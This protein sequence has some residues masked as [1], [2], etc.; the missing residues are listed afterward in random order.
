MSASR[1]AAILASVYVLVAGLYIVLSGRV[2][3]S[4]ARDVQELQVLETYKG[5]GFVLVTALMLFGLAWALGR[6]LIALTER[7]E[8]HQSA[9]LAA[10][11]SASAGLFAASV[12]HDLNNLLMVID[13]CAKEVRLL[14]PDTHELVE[15]IELATARGAQLSKRLMGAASLAQHQ[16][17]E[18]VELGALAAESLELL[19][20]HRLARERELLLDAP[21]PVHVEG[22]PAL[23]HQLI[24]NLLINAL[25][26]SARV[27]RAS[28]RASARGVILDVEDDGP[29]VPEELRDKLFEA[30]YT[31]KAHGTGLGLVSVRA[32]AKLHQ[33]RVE[34]A[35]SDLGGARFR[36]ILQE[37]Q[38]ARSPEMSSMLVLAAA[39]PL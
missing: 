25:D 8:Q 14:A 3:A 5:I 24:M 11:R 17:P 20:L 36:V 12:A 21:S 29:G 34:V 22:H 13:S 28:V 26:A 31:T 9:F 35:R 2:A 33:G 27:V 23:L 32:C 18:Q 37:T 39:T 7:A 4:L 16:T 30:F 19:R 1:Y 6:R 15:D 10:E 38:E